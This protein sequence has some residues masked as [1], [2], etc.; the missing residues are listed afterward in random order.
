[1][2]FLVDLVADAAPAPVGG[3]PLVEEEEEEGGG[4]LAMAMAAGRDFFL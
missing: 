4:V 2:D 3:L 1:V